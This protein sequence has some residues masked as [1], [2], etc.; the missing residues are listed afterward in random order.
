[1]FYLTLH[2]KIYWPTM[3]VDGFGSVQFCTECAR[4]RVKVR[5]NAKRMTL[6]LATAPLEFFATEILGPLL[7]TKQGNEFLL[8]I[9]DRLSKLFKTVPHTF[10]TA[11]AV[12]HAFVTHWIFA[13]GSNNEVL[14][15]T[16]KQ[17]ASCFSQDVCR[18]LDVETLFTT[19][20]HPQETG[21]VARFN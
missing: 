9:T 10:I 18:I 14:S 1:M 12:A 21:E 16:W 6:F 19:T 3:E 20:F 5:R 11:F 15:D 2:S 13:H 4:T 8:V 7:T 17:F